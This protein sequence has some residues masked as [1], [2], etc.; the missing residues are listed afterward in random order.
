MCDR[1]RQYFGGGPLLD[2]E[3]FLHEAHD[4]VVAFVVQH[5]DHAATLF[6]LH[7]R[8]CP[9]EAD[10]CFIALQ[11][12]SQFVCK[13]TALRFGGA[14]SQ[15]AAIATALF[16]AMKFVSQDAALQ[17]FIDKTQLRSTAYVTDADIKS[18]EFPMLA[19][20]GFRVRIPTWWSSA[21]DLAMAS[22][23]PGSDGATEQRSARLLMCT[24]Q[25][26]LLHPDFAE[27]VGLPSR[28]AG[29]SPPR[30]SSSVLCPL[31]HVAASACIAASLA[32]PSLLT[33]IMNLDSGDGELWK[34]MSRL[35][36][37]P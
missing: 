8:A 2:E 5:R 23:A 31:F 9:T 14:K 12:L 29:R 30:T 33:I 28:K 6:Q 26:F 15:S 32:T 21:V 24:V 18:H 36:D 37:G 19:A 25:R 20:C 1:S 11:L 34:E 10:V 4:C 22:T 3:D 13:G 35:L 7:D 27:H 17:D 16:L